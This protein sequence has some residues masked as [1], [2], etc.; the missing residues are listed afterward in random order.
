[1]VKSFKHVRYR[2]KKRLAPVYYPEEA[3]SY[4]IFREGDL[5]YAKYGKTGEIKFE[6]DDAREVIQSA[7]NS[8]E[9]GI[10]FVKGIEEPEGISYKSGVIVIY[11]TPDLKIVS[12]APALQFRESDQT[13][14]AGLYR[15][16]FDGDSVRLDRNTSEAGDFS[17][18]ETV[19]SW[20]Y[21]RET[22]T[23]KGS[24]VVDFVVLRD[25][26]TGNIILRKNDRIELGG[27]NATYGDFRIVFKPNTSPPWTE[28]ENAVFQISRTKD[29]LKFQQITGD[30]SSPTI[31]DIVGMI[32]DAWVP[33][34]DGEFDLGKPWLY[35]RTAY[36]VRPTLKNKGIN[37]SV[38]SGS[39]SLDISLPVEEPDAEY[40]VVVTPH[41]DTT[42]WVTNKT[43]TGFTVNFGTAPSSDS[44]LD[45]LLFR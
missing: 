5:Y 7:I 29:I 12:P 27:E 31:K 41:W 30:P 36:L 21:G 8:I 9:K 37:V 1:M 24:E 6:D 34:S 4:T 22:D 28:G 35:W 3:Y 32:S 26:E 43:T 17:S 10:V 25:M 42:V 44:S 40:G 33:L 15:L 13:L 19:F 14:S 38:P 18:F 39:S 16:V 2:G 45:W 23:V 20:D 11:D